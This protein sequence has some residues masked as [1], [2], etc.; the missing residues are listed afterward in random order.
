M[1]NTSIIEHVLFSCHIY[2]H[3]TISCQSRLSYM[4]INMILLPTSEMV[5]LFVCQ[6]RWYFCI[7]SSWYHQSYSRFKHFYSDSNLTMRNVTQSM[8]FASSQQEIE[9]RCIEKSW[10]THLRSHGYVQQNIW[11]RVH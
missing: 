9:C 7:S 11:T 4:Y 5:S 1:S 2:I 8:H 10:P 3:G 6:L